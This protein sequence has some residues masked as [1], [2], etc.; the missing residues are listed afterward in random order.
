MLADLAGALALFR[1]PAILPEDA[2]ILLV[3]AAWY[4]EEE[5]NGTANGDFRRILFDGEHGIALPIGLSPRSVGAK[6]KRL[7]EM[8]LLE[9]VEPSRKKTPDGFDSPV[10]IRF[11]QPTLDA[12]IQALSRA[13]PFKVPRKP[14]TITTPCENHQLA[15][16]PDCGVPVALPE[17]P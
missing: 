14:R 11:T 12:A 13:T 5:A 17:S 1:N 10:R 6:V 9:R 2:A 15:K 16:C 3:V 4:Y 7:A 8:G